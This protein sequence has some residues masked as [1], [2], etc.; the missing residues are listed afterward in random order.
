MLPADRTIARPYKSLTRVDGR[1]FDL[2]RVHA[3][4]RNWRR[5]KTTEARDNGGTTCDRDDSGYCCVDSRVRL[6]VLGTGQLARFRVKTLRADPR[7]SWIGVGS[8]SPER[9][10]AAAR[11]TQAHAAGDIDDMLAARPD[12]VVVATAT[13]DHANHVQRCLPLGVP[14]LCEK[15]LAN[16]LTESEAVVTAAE[17]AGVLLQIGF[18]RRFDPGFRAAYERI[19]T[20]QVG[21][22]Y[23]LQLT[24]HDHLPPPERYL[25]TRG[26]VFRDLHVHDFDLAR[27]L[28]NEEIDLVFALGANRTEYE[29][30]SAHNDPDSTAM[31]LHTRGGIP[32][33]ISGAQHDPVGH[34]VRAEIF[35]SDDSLAVG[36]DRLALTSVDGARTTPQSNHY[37]NFLDRF[38]HAFVDEVHAFLDVV[39][40]TRANPCPGSEAVEALRIALAAERS[41]REHR[42]IRIAEVT[43]GNDSAKPVPPTEE[44]AYPL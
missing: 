31:V 19:S 25:P 15:P 27:W 3:S 6:I 4:G 21:R 42:A 7:V 43:S 5:L 24:S 29:Y 8:A 32:V 39:A 13:T 9:A 12:A 30:L 1:G 35:G 26:S 17:R 40:G 20:G 28:T 18:Q 34:D 33:L 22:L 11:D 44:S 41:V 38:Y 10:R 2:V 14:V 16:T 23:S 36:L 37:T